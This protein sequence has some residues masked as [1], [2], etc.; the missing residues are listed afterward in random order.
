[1]LNHVDSPYIRCIAFLYLRFATPP[2]D[3]WD[4]FRPYLQD[5]EPVE[6]SPS[7]KRMTVGKY[8]Q[9]LLTDMDYYGTLLPRLPVSIERDI[10]VK[11]L[12][13][14]KIQHRA[15]QHMSDKKLMDYFTKQ[16]GSKIQA[17]YGDDE[18]PTTWYDAVVDKVIYRDEND[19]ELSKPKFIVTFPE[20]GNT[21]TVTLGEIDVPHN[22]SS[23]SYNTGHNNVY[24]SQHR[25]ETLTNYRDRDGCDPPRQ[26]TLSQG[27]SDSRNS[28]HGDRYDRPRHRHNYER[29]YRRSRS[30]SRDRDDGYE[31]QA[32]MEEVRKKE[33]DRIAAKG[34]Q[35]AARPATFKRSLA[36]HSNSRNNH[37][38]YNDRNA[39]T[40]QEHHKSG[41]LQRHR[42]Q[43]QQ[44]QHHVS[45]NTNLETPEELA[46]LEEKRR[47]LQ[48]R[49]G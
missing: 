34:K 49:Y 26:S 6:I 36:S 31:K 17:L 7:N 10:Q 45:H 38:S 3:L 19:I 9:S 12:I 21:E 48:A 11:L 32:L 24:D 47:K 41:H 1:M 23:S 37:Y 25:R 27:Y 14:Q 35:Y 22:H 29:G 15:E 43:Q 4:W 28:I 5:E 16:R 33:R 8:A 2:S 13:E 20:Y 40:N 39:T 30:R 18:N 44:Q 46:A 42:Q